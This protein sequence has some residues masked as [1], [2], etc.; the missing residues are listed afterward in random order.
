MWERPLDGL[1]LLVVDD[2]PD[3]LAMLDAALTLSGAVV[4][5]A[6][7]GH[8]GLEQLARE[9]VDVIISDISMPT[10]SSDEF[11]TAVRAV[12]SDAQHRIPA[13]ALTAVDG[14]AQRRRVLQ[15][16]FQAYFRKPVDLDELAQEIVRL[17]EARGRARAA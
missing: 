14:P 15:G 17:A 4:L 9:R 8:E 6:R 3:V 10:F 7:N 13:I 12:T 5:R 2:N 16:G 11:I 1:T